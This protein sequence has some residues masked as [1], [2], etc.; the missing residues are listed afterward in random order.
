M[1]LKI[2]YNFRILI[3]IKFAI[4]NPKLHHARMQIMEDNI[5]WDFIK[6]SLFIIYEAAKR[7]L[8]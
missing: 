2:L 4:T 7:Y 5:H 8:L 6:L 1:N 3:K